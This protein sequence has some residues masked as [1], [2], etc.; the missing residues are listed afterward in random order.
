M[1]VALCCGLVVC[2]QFLFKVMR[3]LIYREIL[4]MHLS[5]FIYYA[6]YSSYIVSV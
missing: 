6:S 2:I 1:L 3:V 4:E 5:V